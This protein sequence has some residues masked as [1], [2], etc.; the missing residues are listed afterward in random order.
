MATL[1]GRAHNDYHNVLATPQIG[2]PARKEPRAP[3][4]FAT[5]DLVWVG[6]C[7][8]DEHLLVS[9]EVVWMVLPTCCPLP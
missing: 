3:E 6:K 8:G 4:A 1:G 2:I 7:G 5:A 9:G